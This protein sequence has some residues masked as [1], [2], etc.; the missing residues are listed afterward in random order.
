MKEAHGKENTRKGIFAVESINDKP[1]VESNEELKPGGIMGLL[2]R[3]KY[4]GI[5]SINDA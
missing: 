3:R 5:I 1:I 2:L 4:K